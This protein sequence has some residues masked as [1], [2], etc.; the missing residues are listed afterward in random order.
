[1][2]TGVRNAD[3]ITSVPSRII[4]VP[5]KEEAMLTCCPFLLPWDG[6]S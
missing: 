5:A 1:L 4:F 6:T 2:G 3:E